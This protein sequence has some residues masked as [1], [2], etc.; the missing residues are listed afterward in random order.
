MRALMWCL[1]WLVLFLPAVHVAERLAL[2][3]G[4]DARD[5]IAYRLYDANGNEFANGPWAAPRIGLEGYVVDVVENAERIVFEVPFERAADDDQPLGLYFSLQE[6]TLEVRVNGTVIRSTKSI[7]KFEGMLTSEPAFYAMPVD[8]LIV[9]QNWLEIHKTAMG[10][11]M[12]LSPFAVGPADELIEAYRWR[13]FFVIDLG[14]ISIGVQLF[15][16][17]LMALINWPETERPRIRALMLIIALNAA[18]IYFLSF[19][20]PFEMTLAQFVYLWSGLNLALGLAVLAF[21]AFDSAV[22]LPIRMRWVW[23]GIFAAHAA[24]FAVLPLDV[25]RSLT[26]LVNVPYG[27]LSVTTLASILLLALAVIRSN[28]ARR[29]ERSV[30]ALSF[31][32]MALDRIGSLIDLHSPFDA[33]LPMTLTWGPI[34]GTFLGLS[35]L[36]ALAREAARAR[37]VVDQAN[38]RL[39]QALAA[40]EAELAESYRQREAIQRQAAVLEERQ[41]L[42]RDMHD[43]IGGQLMSLKLKAESGSLDQATLKSGVTN[44]LNDLRLIVDSLDSAEDGVSLTLVAFERRLRQQL[45]GTGVTLKVIDETG[46]A[47]A[48]L[49]PRQI[50]NVLRVLQEAVTNALAHGKATL[51]EL[52]A[53]FADDERNFEFLLIDNGSGID[54]TQPAGHGLRNMQQRAAAIGGVCAVDSDASGTRVRICVP[55]AAAVS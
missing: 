32:A 54:A 27:F 22:R 38:Q 9:G 2:P 52:R 23:V 6:Q 28:P 35:M 40:R 8:S 3:E 16:L 55:A 42:V 44:S 24:A 7:P 18:A 43:G 51:L 20:P 39:A 21:A 19:R 15:V 10:V 13:S 12:A 45:A 36:L 50:L 37:E 11:D 30:L 53:R 31:G 4:M 17:L 41:R 1:F 47:H 49:A 14:L 33:S 26:K 34:L 46:N 29:F 48:A 5:S 25:D